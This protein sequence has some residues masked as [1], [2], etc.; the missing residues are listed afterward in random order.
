MLFL[1][2]IIRNDSWIKFRIKLTPCHPEERSR[3]H[4]SLNNITSS[5]GSST[6]PFCEDPEP[7]R[8]IAYDHFTGEGSGTMAAHLSELVARTISFTRKSFMREQSIPC[9]FRMHIP[10]ATRI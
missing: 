10:S 7:G 9:G 3:R 5:E 4:C 1:A 2:K 6:A 8:H